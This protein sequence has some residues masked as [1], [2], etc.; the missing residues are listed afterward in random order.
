[1]LY[2]ILFPLSHEFIFFNVF[3]YISFRT[4]GAL[5]TALILFFILGKWMIRFLQSWQVT[6]TIRSDG[7]KSHL[8]KAGTPTM[9]GILILFCTLVSVLLWMDISN[10]AVWLVL[11]LYTAYAFIGFWDDYQ[12][13]HHGSSKGLSGKKKLIGQIVVATVVSYLLIHYLPNTRLALPFFKTVQPELNGWYLP[14]AVLVIVGASNAVNLTDGLDGLASGPSVMAFMTYMILA[15]LSGH[16]KIA[17]YLQIPY[18]PGSGELAIFCGA[19]IGALIGFLW[20]NTY[21]A[22]IFMGDVGSLPLGGALGTMAIA[23]KNEILLMIVGGVF[24]LEAVSVMTQVASFK[25]TGKRIFRMAPIHHHFELKGWEEP[26]IIVRFWM[27]SFI[28]ALVA[29]ATLKLR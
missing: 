5:A 21:P 6:Q 22:Q 26:K 8:E 4:F 12:K 19:I 1:M 9:G 10:Q 28:L 14:F 27:V 13:I 15:Y 20:F 24:V 16:A 23:T 25:L 7:P 11:G 17:G 2:K 3:K 18:I 29:L